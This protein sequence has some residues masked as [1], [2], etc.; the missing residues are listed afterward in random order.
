MH[1][2]QHKLQIYNL[3]FKHSIIYLNKLSTQK[4]N[5]F[6]GNKITFKKYFL[7][8]KRSKVKLVTYIE[9]E[10]DTI[11]TKCSII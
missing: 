9:Y 2:T 8:D 7:T 11:A 4:K 5:W 1:N 10:I 3:Y 6:R